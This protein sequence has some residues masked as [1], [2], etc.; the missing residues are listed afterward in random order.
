MSALL[1]GVESTLRHAYELGFNVTLPL[2]G[3]TDL[4][5]EPH[6]DSVT[7]IFPRLGETGSSREI[8]DLPVRA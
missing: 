5:P 6:D 3:V 7:W 8:V 2:D 4:S 1:M